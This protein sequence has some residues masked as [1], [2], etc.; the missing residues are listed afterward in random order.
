LERSVHLDLFW[1]Y[2]S[3]NHAQQ[4]FLN[5]ALFIPLGFLLANIFIAHPNRHLWIIFSGF[6]V[7]I[8]VEAAQFFTYRGMLDIDDLVSNVLGTV[9]GMLIWQI[10]RRIKPHKAVS[11]LMIGAEILGCVAVAV[12]AAKSNIS[13]RVTRQFDFTVDSVYGN[14][15]KVN[16]T[17]TCYTYKRATPSYEIFIGEAKANSTVEGNNYQAAGEKIEEKAEVRIK[18][19][20]YGLMPTGTYLRPTED[21]ISVEYVAGDVK[22]P[23]GVPDNAVLKAYNE[24]HDVLIYQDGDR[25]LWLIGDSNID[26]NTEIIYHIHTDEP[27]KLP[28]HR[29]QYGF[30]NRGFRVS[31]DQKAANELDGIDHYRVF[32][33]EI[34]EEYRVTAVI[35]GFN[36][37]GTVTWTD[38]FRIE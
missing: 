12:P 17:G 33:K 3:Q 29:V 10:V 13:T 37:D 4:I 14:D 30:D 23:A 11:W 6:A 9:V 38:S 21:G 31:V 1:S 19:R 32:Q 22:E 36:T 15:E 35:V 2:L 7:S 20:G 5:V 24:E 27:E 8:V 18:F 16:L 28:E 34:P 25:L 26:R